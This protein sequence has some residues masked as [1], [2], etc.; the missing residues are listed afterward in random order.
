MKQIK[1]KTN[2][3][4]TFGIFP[5]SFLKRLEELGIP[6][7][8]QKYPNDIRPV[9]QD[10]R[11]HQLHLC[12]GASPT[13]NDCPGYGTKHSDDEVPVIRSTPLLLGEV[14]FYR[15]LSMGQIRLNCVLMLNWIV[16]NGT[17]FDLETVLTRN[18]I[19]RNRTVY[20][21]ENGFGIK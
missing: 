13:P 4:D 8:N 9:G 18:W 3:W 2:I 15:V 6:K 7:K 21:Y 19:V 11:I 16:W 17:V 20:L 10:S 1:M 12:R 5:K 14:A